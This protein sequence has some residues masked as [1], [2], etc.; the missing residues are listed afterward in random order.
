M[1][2]VRR[3]CIYNFDRDK[4]EECQSCINDSNY[5]VRP[6]DLAKPGASAERISSVI[7]CAR[8]RGNG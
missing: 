7:R 8:T 4:N 1:F 5:T 2:C 3:S 6:A